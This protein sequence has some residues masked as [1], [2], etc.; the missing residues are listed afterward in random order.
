MKKNKIMIIIW[1]W[2]PRCLKNKKVDKYRIIE[3]ISQ[4][5]TDD[6][7]FFKIKKLNSQYKNDEILIFVHKQDKDR[8]ATLIKLIES[9]FQELKNIKIMP[10]FGELVGELYY[11]NI[12]K[13]GLLGMTCYKDDI[14]EENFDHVWKY[15]WENKDEKK[16]S[17]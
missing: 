17:S 3:P 5:L 7:I 6:E 2:A 15:Y 14:T 8:T 1:K 9:E 13:R 10:P 4:S 11:D 16:N 12:Q